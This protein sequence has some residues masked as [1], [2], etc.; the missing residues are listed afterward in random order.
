MRQDVSPYMS[1]QPEPAALSARAPG[2]IMR[3]LDAR[4]HAALAALLDTDPGRGVFLADTLERYGVTPPFAGFWGAF[5]GGGLVAAL[6]LVGRR[7]APFALPGADLAPLARVAVSEGLDF[8]MGRAAEVDA[9][10]A[11]LPAG[12]RVLREEHHLAEH[13]PPRA[14]ET[15]ISPPPAT[16]IRRAV[17]GDLD[18]LAR[19]YFRTD[20]FEHLTWEHLRQTL[21]GRIRGLR[22]YVAE[23]RGRLVSAASTSAETARAAMIG[24]VWTAPDARN[25]G[26]STAVV[27]A[28]SRELHGEGRRAFLFYLMDNAPAA[29]VYARAGYRVAGRWSVAYIALED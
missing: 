5:T 2:V 20:G 6:M 14:R 23:T 9:L 29:V 12:H 4:D 10:L 16:T 15:P 8:T 25:R 24:G 21:D 27:A 28:L 11:A 1:G 18:A 22:T 7:A 26:H 3:R 19:L 17:P 13:L